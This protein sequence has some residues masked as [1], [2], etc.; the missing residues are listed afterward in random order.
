MEG[1]EVYKN[2]VTAM[3][4]AAREVM[5]RAGLSMGDIKCVIPH[6][7]NQRIIDAVGQRLG[8]DPDKVF[9][10]LHKY[11]NTSAASVAVALREA[12]D[13]GCIERGDLV[14]MIAFGAGLTWGATVL[15]W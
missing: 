6:Q 14:L 1:K 4:A 10:N 3:T 11:G 7:A 5:D 15:E 12:V 2:A 9:V 13:A 8:V